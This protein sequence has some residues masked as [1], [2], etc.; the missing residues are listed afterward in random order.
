M[1]IE[2]IKLFDELVNLHNIINFIIKHNNHNTLNS[3][4]I[5]LKI[6]NILFLVN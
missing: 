5:F 1:I 4:G 6:I 2:Y 3:Q